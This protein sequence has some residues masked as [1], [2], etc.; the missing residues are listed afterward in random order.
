M[1]CR[2]NYFIFG[3]FG[4]FLD[5]LR[6]IRKKVKIFK[7]SPKFKLLPDF[8]KLCTKMF[9]RSRAFKNWQKKFFLKGSKGVKKGS[10]FKN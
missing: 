7:N 2:K 1:I 5:I 8:Q 6:K 4:E 3:L 9:G 10:K